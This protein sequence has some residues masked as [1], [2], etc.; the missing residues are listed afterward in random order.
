ML[1]RSRV[2]VRLVLGRSALRGDP[3][4]W[5]FYWGLPSGIICRSLFLNWLVSQKGNVLHVVSGANRV[6][7]LSS[8]FAVLVSNQQNAK[9]ESS[10]EI[11]SYF[12]T[13]DLR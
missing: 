7:K 9:W 2:G 5:L 6:K 3:G 13:I 1:R 8:L 12:K 10:M 11:L 4:G